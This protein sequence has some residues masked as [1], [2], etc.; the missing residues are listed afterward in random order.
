MP[1]GLLASTYKCI[2]CLK[3][4]GL[5]N[6]QIYFEKSNVVSTWLFIKP[7]IESGRSYSGLIYSGK[8]LVFIVFYKLTL[9]GKS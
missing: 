6:Y 5:S 8:F 2:L 7:I 4:P 1:K 3:S 9:I